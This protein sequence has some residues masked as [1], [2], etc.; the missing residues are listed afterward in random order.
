ME[1]IGWVAPQEVSEIIPPRG[2]AFDP[3]VIERAAHY[4]AL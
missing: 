1:I 4:N 2:A 3:A